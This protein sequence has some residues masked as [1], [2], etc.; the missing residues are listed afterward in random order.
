LWE[1]GKIV[2][3]LFRIQFTNHPLKRKSWKKYS[4]ANPTVSEL[5]TMHSASLV[6]STLARAFFKVE[7]N[8]LIFKTR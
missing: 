4:R 3:T 1:R 6:V 5:T 8:I 2:L 7:E